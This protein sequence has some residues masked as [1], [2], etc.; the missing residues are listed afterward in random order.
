MDLLE[1]RGGRRNGRV[2]PDQAPGLRRRQR[3]HR[4]SPDERGAGVQVA[5]GSSVVTGAVPIVRRVT[6]AAGKNAPA[7]PAGPAQPGTKGT[8]TPAPAP[9]PTPTAPAAPVVTP[10]VTTPS[11]GAAAVEQPSAVV[12]GGVT[13]GA[14]G[15]VG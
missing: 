14:A 3:S 12:T 13:T 4:R 10:P 7:G 1:R 11:T 2:V 8:P 5:P 6:P 9:T 15:A